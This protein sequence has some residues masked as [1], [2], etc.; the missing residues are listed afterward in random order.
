MR[1]RLDFASGHTSKL[2]KP[3]R[4][5]LNVPRKRDM[6]DAKLAQ[7]TYI[8][9]VCP[10]ISGVSAGSSPDTRSWSFTQAVSM[11]KHIFEPASENTIT[12]AACDPFTDLL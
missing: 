7:S 4:D 9:M 12:G 2:G 1:I 6:A 10:G 11:E 8:S 3:L 5:R